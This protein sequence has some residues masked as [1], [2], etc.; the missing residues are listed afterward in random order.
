MIIGKECFIGIEFKLQFS[1]L[2]WQ[3]FLNKYNF[4][5]WIKLSQWIYLFYEVLRYPDIFNILFTFKIIL[6]SE[7]GIFS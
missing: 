5:S 4:D 2:I 6:G 7:K 3:F 1:V